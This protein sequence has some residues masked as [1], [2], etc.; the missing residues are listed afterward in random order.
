MYYAAVTTVALTMVAGSNLSNAIDTSA[1]YDNYPYV[2]AP[3]RRSTCFDPAYS[4]FAAENNS[5]PPVPVYLASSPMPLPRP[6]E[7]R[8]GVAWL[9]SH[10]GG[11]R[12][13]RALRD[14]VERKDALLW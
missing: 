13:R 10:Q 1:P 7:A 3:R 5:P 6:P 12:E 8:G 9:A 4:L 2:E 14:Q 11:P